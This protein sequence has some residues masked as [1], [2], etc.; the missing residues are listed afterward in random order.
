MRRTPAL[1]SR[2]MSTRPQ[3]AAATGQP[4]ALF[5]QATSAMVRAGG[6]VQLQLA[7][8]AGLL[9]QQAVRQ[10][11]QATNPAEVLTVQ[12]A[13]VLAGWQ[14]SMECSQALVHAW[15]A[16]LETGADPTGSSLH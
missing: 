6:D 1:E 16:A 2:P 10:L 15:R 4:L 7:R 8:S 13:L 9:Q 3:G 5:S 11:R 14:Q 12:T